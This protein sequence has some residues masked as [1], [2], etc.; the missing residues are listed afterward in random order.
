[1][2]KSQ[3]QGVSFDEFVRF[4]LSPAQ[5][6]KLQT[7]IVQLGQIEELVQQTD[8]LETVRRMVPLL[9]AEAEKVMRTNQRLSAT[10]RR[11]LDGQAHRERQRV[12]LLLQE[13]RALAAAY[14]N[15][16]PRD[17]VQVEV[18]TKIEIASPF[19]RTFWVE[20]PKFEKIDLTECVANDSKR[21]EAFKLLAQMQRLEW[22]KM[23]D[24]VRSAV[25]R[26]GSTTL[27]TLLEEHPP[28]AGMIEVLGYLQIAQDDGHLV[29]R[30]AEEEILLPPS[31]PGRSPLAVT[32]PLVRFQE[33]GTLP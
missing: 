1:M 18:D 10:L 29:S 2:L 4:I 27:A 23:R 3:D 28:Q 26:Q 5:Q 16:P 24:R 9:L 31:R 7:I 12:A 8:G 25:K 6:E 19:S 33:I 32:I 14:A 30:D 11:L 15:H 21:L 17:Q 13:I 20:P 22:S